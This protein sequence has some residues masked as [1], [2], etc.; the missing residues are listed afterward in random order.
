MAAS[1]DDLGAFRRLEGAGIAGGQ[2]EQL[3]DALKGSSAVRTG[4][5][6]SLEE[7]ELMVDGIGR[8]KIS[9]LTT[10]VIRTHLIEYTD[11]Q[12]ELYG[13]PTK[14]VALPPCFDV[15][16]MSW[17]ER[18]AKLPVYKSKPILLVPKSIVRYA[19]AY[20]NQKYYQHHVLNFLKAQEL[21]NPQS[22]LVKVLKLKKGQIVRRITKKTL[23][24]HFPNTKN[25]LF[26]FSRKHP[27]VLKSYR[28]DLEAWSARAVLTS[29]E[30][31]TNR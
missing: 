17:E 22:R 8:D 9:D 30:P 27:E 12:C 6:N 21:A 4:F 2:A 5:I 11:S 19:P 16:S 13:I 26:E 7:A 28:Q 3:F 15:E 31:K 23:Q 24:K 10:N 14:E 29:F 18:F 20:Q 1:Q 25:Y